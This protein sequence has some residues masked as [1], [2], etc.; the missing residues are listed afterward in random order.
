[1]RF[2][3]IRVLDTFFF[4]PAMYFLSIPPV[5]SDLKFVT[6]NNGHWIISVHSSI[7]IISRCLSIISILKPSNTK[8]WV[9]NHP[10]TTFN[11][12]GIRYN[13]LKPEQ[14]LTIKLFSLSSHLLFNNK[15]NRITQLRPGYHSDPWLSVPASQQVLLY[16]VKIFLSKC[17]I[18]ANP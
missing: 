17:N 11:K 15:K 1:M 4:F 6:T 12:R 13:L 3:S 16:L 2:S 5:A 10:N 18:H 9:I 7:C 8:V 14:A